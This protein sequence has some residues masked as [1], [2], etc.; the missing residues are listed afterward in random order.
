MSTEDVENNSIQISYSLIIGLIIV[1]LALV[2]ALNVIFLADSSRQVTMNSDG[3]QIFSILE[4]NLTFIIDDNNVVTIYG[5]GDPSTIT[6]SSSKF[7]DSTSDRLN[8]LKFNG[9]DSGLISEIANNPKSVNLSVTFLESGIYQGLIFISADTSKTTTVPFTVDIKPRI[10]HPIMY[11]IDGIVISIA[12]WKLIK[13]FNGMYGSI[14]INDMKVADPTRKRRG[15][16]EYLNDSKLTNI[17]ILKNGI[18]D[19][20]TIIFGIALGLIALLNDPFVL[21]L[22]SIGTFDILILMGMGLG[23]GSLKEFITK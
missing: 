16:A 12:L 23:I 19:I 14:I 22:H 5:T 13:Y 20:A 1:G 17:A 21:G 6:L 18:V 7:M 2:V 3:S 10:S 15:I 4:D 8:Q 11:I 9:S